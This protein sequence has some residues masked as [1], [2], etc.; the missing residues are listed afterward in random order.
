MSTMKK[1]ELIVLCIFSEFRLSIVIPYRNLPSSY[2]N[3]LCKFN[4]D[5]LV[6]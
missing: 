6:N 1:R 4:Y 3:V 2:K 5:Q